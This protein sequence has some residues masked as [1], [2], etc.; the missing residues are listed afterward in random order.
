MDAKLVSLNMM[1]KIF[2]ASY[3]SLVSKLP[4]V[5]EK[6]YS[7]ENIVVS[8]A[9]ASSYIYVKGSEPFMVVAHL[10]TVHKTLCTEINYKFYKKDSR[11]ITSLSSPQG[12]GGDDRC[13]VIL[14]LSLLNSTNLRPSI[15]FTCGEEIGGYGARAFTKQVKELSLNFIVEFDR[16]GNTDVVRYSDDSLELTK[17]LESFGFKLS[18]GS[19]SDISILAPHYGISAVNLSS[20]YYNA[21]TTNE[22]VIV[23]EMEDILNKAVAFFISDKA[24][25]VYK[26]KEKVRQPFSFPPQDISSFNYKQGNLFE[27]KSYCDFCNRLEDIEDLIETSDGSVVCKDCAEHLIQSNGYIACPHCGTL[28]YTEDYDGFCAFCGGDLNE[29]ETNK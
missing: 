24:K 23:E 9:D 8:S 7:K 20:G 11:T 2:K 15:L 27:D 21:H 4:N 5:L 1:H 25:E 12:I 10:D 6:F 19:F 3:S 13:G 18:W 14:I 29:N 17:A 16:K 28:L 22:Y 26:Y